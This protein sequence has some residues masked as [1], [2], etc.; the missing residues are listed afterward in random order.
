[1]AGLVLVC[2]L[3][4]AVPTVAKILKGTRGNDT[5]IGGKRG[6]QLLGKRGNDVLKGRKGPDLLV[7]N[8]GKDVLKGGRNFDE[9][10]AGKDNDRILAR[11]SKRDQIDCGA[12]LDTA[13]VDRNED[14][15]FNCERVRVRG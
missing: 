14:G 2:A 6:D 8:A 12:G 13:V 10:R 1:V 15:I 11:D 5:L 3:V 9:I 7:G 4:F